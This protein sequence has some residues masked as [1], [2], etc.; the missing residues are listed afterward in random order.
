MWC[1]R[2]WWPKKTFVQKKATIFLKIIITYLGISF[3]GSV[4]VLNPLSLPPALEVDL[5]LDPDPL[6]KHPSTESLEAT[7]V[8]R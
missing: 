5:G 3:A 7:L 4:G 8:W 6:E 1:F 2:R